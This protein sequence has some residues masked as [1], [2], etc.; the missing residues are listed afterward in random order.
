MSN[1]ENT[2]MNN[3]RE[4]P[5]RVYHFAYTHDVINMYYVIYIYISRE[6]LNF[7]LVV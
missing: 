6:V 4:I 5:A 3:R 2:T 7:G 1:N